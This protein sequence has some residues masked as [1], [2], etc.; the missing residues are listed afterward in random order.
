MSGAIFAVIMRGGLTTLEVAFGAWLI[1]TVLGLVFA[2]LRHFGGRPVTWM[3]GILVAILRGVP[4]LVVLYFAFFGLP[5]LGINLS[6]VMAAIVALG[7]CEASFT[8]EYYRAAIATVAREQ[9]DAGRSL[10]LSNL[11]IFGLIV[12]PQALVVAVPALLNSLLGLLKLATLASAVGTP[13]ILYNSQ[14]E[15]NRAGHL[16]GIAATVI[17]V[18]LVVSLPG[19]HLVRRLE[20][21]VSKHLLAA[22]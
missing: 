4:Q 3:L 20:R 12:M 10:G 9:E 22:T 16:L 18:Y 21:K 7:I 2:I 1:G 14:L 17:A 13:E 15:M 8:A 5:T 6:S 19:I 11:K